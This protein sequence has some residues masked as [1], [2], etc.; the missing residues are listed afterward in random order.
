MKKKN[1]MEMIP[2]RNNRIHWYKNDDKVVLEIRRQGKLHNL[3]HK[4]FKTPLTSTINLEELGSFVWENCDGQNSLYAISQKLEEE[5]GDRAMPV[6][7]RLI[8]YIRVLTN[9]NLITL[10]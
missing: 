8:Q 9:N 3:L 6:T 2:K 5:F 10:E 1:T 4:V 7:A